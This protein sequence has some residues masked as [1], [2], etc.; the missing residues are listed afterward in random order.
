M[1]HLDYHDAVHKQLDFCFAV[2]RESV[3]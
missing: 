3:E 1:V 2:L